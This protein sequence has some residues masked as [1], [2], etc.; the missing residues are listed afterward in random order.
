MNKEAGKGQGY[1]R[2]LLFFSSNT[3]DQVYAQVWGVDEAAGKAMDATTCSFGTFENT[4]SAEFKSPMALSFKSI[5]L[6]SGQPTTIEGNVSSP[7][8]ASRRV[9]CGIKKHCAK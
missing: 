3:C 9:C 4:D 6:T 7:V 1:P 8:A 2:N 5:S